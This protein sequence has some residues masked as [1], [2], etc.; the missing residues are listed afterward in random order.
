MSSSMNLFKF[1]RL[2]KDNYGIWCIRMKALLGS[3]DVLVIVEKGI[4]KYDDESSLIAAQR[5]ELQKARKK[6][7]SAL[8]LIYQCLD[9]VMFDKVTNASTCK[10]SW[11]IL[12]NAFKR[13]D[14]VKRRNGESLSDTKVIEKILRSLPPSFDYIVVAIEESK[15]IDF[16]TIDQLMRS[17]Q[18][19][20]EK[21]KDEDAIL[22][23][24]VVV[25]KD[26]DEE[27]E[28]KMSTK[29]MRTNGLDVSLCVASLG[30]NFSLRDWHE[31]LDTKAM[32][33]YAISSLLDT[34]CR[35]SEQYLQLSLFKL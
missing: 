34:A 30:E 23:M 28:E 20:E 17:L 21:N 5:V 35:L 15:D 26:M 29:K 9:D 25:S 8:T 32:H 2:T 13:I 19:H 3:H 4:E 10:E 33:R 7:H 11:E 18:A 31:I 27:E 6:D 1:P 12:P 24:V 22:F 14:K 16:M